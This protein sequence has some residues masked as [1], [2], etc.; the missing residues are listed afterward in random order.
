[1]KTEQDYLAIENGDRA[2]AEIA[3]WT[4]LNREINLIF[5]TAVR[6]KPLTLGEIAEGRGRVAR[7]ARKLI[8]KGHNPNATLDNK[9]GQWK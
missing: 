7:K 1:M 3:M 4:D 6:M 8:A 2:K 5:G 9:T